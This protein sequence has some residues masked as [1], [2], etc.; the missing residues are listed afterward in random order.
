MC[1]KLKGVSNQIDNINTCQVFFTF[2]ESAKRGKKGVILS[3]SFK[4]ISW[5]GLA[6]FEPIKYQC[7]HPIETNHLNCMSG[8]IATLT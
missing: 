8:L 2:S 6:R 7:N 4:H 3:T 5:G 1:S